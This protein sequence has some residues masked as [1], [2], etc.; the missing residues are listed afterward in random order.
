MTVKRR[1]RFDVFFILYLTAILGFVVITHQRSKTS[2][3]IEQKAYDIARTF[4]P[5]ARMEFDADT[6]FWYVD[7]DDQTGETRRGPQDFSSRLIIHDITVEDSVTVTS[8][9]HTRND[10]VRFDPIV[11]IGPMRGADDPDGRMAS[12]PFTCSIRKTGV[13]RIAFMGK[14]RRVHGMAGGSR[15]YRGISF[16]TDL[17]P[18]TLIDRLE[19]THDTLTAIV[20]D[21]SV[22]NPTTG[23]PL[24]VQ[25]SQPVLVGAIGFETSTTLVTNLGWKKPTF[26]IVRGGGVLEPAGADLRESTVRWRGTPRLTTDTVV[27]DAAIDRGAGG[28]DH[29]RTSFVV[30]AV[31]PVL[32]QSVPSVLYAGEEASFSVRVRGLDDPA[33]YAWSIDNTMGKGSIVSMRIPSDYGGRTIRLRATCH[34]SLYPWRDPVRHTSGRSEFAIPVVEPPMH[35]VFTPPPDPSWRTVFTFTAAR[36]SDPKYLLAAPVKDLDQIHVQAMR[37]NG[38]NLR[39]ELAMVRNGLFAFN[40]ENGDMVK[41]ETIELVITCGEAVLTRTVRFRMD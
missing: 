20:R 16:T 27:I 1:R 25:A 15:T 4:L 24:M 17:V 22:T 9:S 13:Y 33:S 2:N 6:L 28:R 29:A 32:E 8:I 30:N 23:E 38:A 18:D 12:V 40:L 31:A 39:V 7:A 14:T 35:I 10:T 11:T 41:G 21:T 37:S 36:W 3:D 19:T 5:P 26:R 34:G